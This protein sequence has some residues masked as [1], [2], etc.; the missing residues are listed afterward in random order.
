MGLKQTGPIGINYSMDY[1]IVFIFYNIVPV[2]WLFVRG[3][4]KTIGVCYIVFCV[5]LKSMVFPLGLGNVFVPCF[6]AYF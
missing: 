1:G 6:Y 3:V 2:I 5:L 4:L